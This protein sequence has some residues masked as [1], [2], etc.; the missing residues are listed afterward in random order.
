MIETADSLSK[1]V[2]DRISLYQFYRDIK[3]K[4]KLELVGD[5]ETLRDRF[6]ENKYLSRTGLA[7]SG[8]LDVF[9]ENR[10][11]VIGNTESHYLCRHQ[12]ADL[13]LALRQLATHSIPCF[14]I[15][16]GNQVPDFFYST[17]AEFHIP[18]FKSGF[19]SDIVFYHLTNYLWK[20]FSET[21]FL[22][23][24]L[25]EVYSVGIMIQGKPGVGKSE[26]ALELIN[27][28]HRLVADDIVVIK[29]TI[30]D[31]LVGEPQELL[32]N[33]IEIRGIGII[34]LKEIFGVRSILHHKRIDILVS[35]EMASPKI[36]FERLG[37]DEVQQSIL[38]VQ[39]PIVKVPIRPGKNV[40]S[41]LETIALNFISKKNGYN[42]PEVLNQNLLR[43]M[44]I[45]QATGG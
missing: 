14:F 38:G 31:L 7:M 42:A 16:N 40:A 6:I 11:Q 18:I 26:A 3:E 15:T 10:I 24:C 23:G 9:P 45:N 37:L 43:K 39:I 32:Q 22:H 25:V 1:L 2:P 27:L 19:S 34:N 36:Y 28:G 29:K 12:S 35:L 5:E 41:I 4:L 21:T 20:R 30:G 8:F 13:I 17:M 44:S 33:F